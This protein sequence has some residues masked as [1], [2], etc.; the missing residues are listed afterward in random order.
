MAKKT[1]KKVATKKK[2]KEAEKH[3]GGR[4]RQGATVKIRV[5]GRIE[6][7]HLASIKSQYKTIQRFID[8]AVESLIKA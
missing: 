1:T 7:A 6:E 8:K 5:S 4:P 2:A 3:A